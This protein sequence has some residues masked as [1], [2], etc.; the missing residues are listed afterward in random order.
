M[1]TAE[2]FPK[3]DETLVISG[4]ELVAWQRSLSQAI[5]D[6]ETLIEVLSLPR[7]WTEVAR[8][9]GNQFPLLVPKSYVAKMRS[10]DINDPLLRQVLP[11]GE[12]LV[13]SAGFSVDAVGDANSRRAP[14]LLHKYQGRALLV[15]TGSCAI[16]CR[17]CFRRH[18]PY[19]EDP[20][21]MD[22]W[23]SAFRVLEAD[24]SIHEI[25]L[26]GGDPL[27]LTDHRLGE[28]VHRLAAIPHLRRLR[29]H[30]R[31]PIVLPNRVNERLLKLLR[32]CRLRTIMVVHANHPNE[33]VDDCEDALRTLVRSGITTFN[34]AVLLRGVNDH[35]D[36]LV[37]LH[38]R[39]IDVGV[40]P[41]YL[42]QL[43][44]V[45][46]VGHF[47]VDESIGLKLIAELRRRL[48]GYAVP[49]YVR[50]VAGAEFK[51]PIHDSK[52]G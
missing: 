18:Y 33:V 37:Q 3:M 36:V 43:D 26:S 52:H 22:E 35:A 25:I 20:R 4:K 5:R 10:G 8:R 23:E 45:Q 17:Y 29:I 15:A 21:R 7:E 44:R 2:T 16:H 50:E 11:L 28:L 14:G 19:R 12:E 39:L 30:S 6:P 24:H 41:Y 32:E 13:A 40:V 34:Q 42:H 49:E 27:M 38:E 51:V 1:E 48:P 31:L 9:A 46:G 47:E